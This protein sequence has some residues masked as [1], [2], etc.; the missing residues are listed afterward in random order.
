MVYGIARTLK[1]LNNALIMLNFQGV[2]IKT[3]NA[4]LTTFVLGFENLEV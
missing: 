4:Y 2:K 1:M 3:K